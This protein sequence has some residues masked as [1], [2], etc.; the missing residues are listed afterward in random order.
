MGIAVSVCVISLHMVL[1]G[2]LSG[3]LESSN[4]GSGWMI[5]AVVF[6]L[7]TL[8]ILA[9]VAYRLYAAVR[10]RHLIDNV[11]PFGVIEDRR[12]LSCEAVMIPV[13]E[14][15]HL[16][17]SLYQPTTTALG[18]VVFCHELDGNRW[19]AMSYA[20]ALV[21]AGFAVLSFD[22]H[23]HGDSVV[24]ESYAPIHWVT[25][26]EVD[27]LQATLR[28]AKSQDRL[29]GLKIGLFGVSRGA[30]AA[31]IVASIRSD[32][33][34]VVTDSAYTTRSMIWSF[35]G[36]F[37]RHVCPNWFFELLPDWHVWQ[38]INAAIRSSERRSGRRYVHLEDVVGQLE[39]RVLLIAGSRD[40][41]VTKLVR[42]QLSN[43]LPP[44][45]DSWLVSKARHNRARQQSPEEYD[46]RI[47][48]HF[49][50]YL[51]GCSVA[52]DSRQATSAR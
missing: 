34:A 3:R 46:A 29:S 48:Q 7:I 10:I 42:E 40:S 2:H 30:C 13:G 41:Y 16:A 15:R 38:D 24:D 12:D 32:I 43:T 21:E 17:A 35:T 52:A 5:A 23:N 51:A 25:E 45:S 14:G 1:S 11:P 8:V 31:L 28:W 44:A 39:S 9:D 33:A 37:S 20:E 36:R 47:V 50:T 27:D 4:V 26:I 18:L 6:G 22:F 19:T 49:S